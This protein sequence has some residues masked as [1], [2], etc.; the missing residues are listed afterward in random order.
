MASITT[1]LDVAMN[2]MLDDIING[3]AKDGLVVLKQVLD[4]SG[5]L[6]SPYLKNYEVYAHVIGHQVMYEILVDVTALNEKEKQTRELI[7]SA[8]DNEISKS[9]KT[10]GV[11]AKG[12]RR[13]SK[14]KDVRK[15]VGDVRKTSHDARKT[16]HNRLLEHDSANHA[17]RSMEVNREGKLSVYY[18]RSIRETKSG[19]KYPQF[20]YDGLM[21]KFLDK[22]I[23][24]VSERFTSEIEKILS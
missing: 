20:K 19:I 4:S 9:A 11:S 24:T 10:Y 7:D 21:Q 13:I 3:V 15:E 23:D 6:K 17:P 12:V 8:V 16:S 2:R 18:E 5:F 22:L 1:T 14:M